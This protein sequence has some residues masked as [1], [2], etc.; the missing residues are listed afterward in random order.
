MVGIV[1]NKLVGIDEVDHRLHARF[2]RRLG[3]QVNIAAGIVADAAVIP[4]VRIVAVGI[5]AVAAAAGVVAP[6]LA[7]HAPAAR[8][9]LLIVQIAVGIDH[10]DEVG[11]PVVDQ[12]GDL[13]IASVVLAE[14]ADRL[15]Q[16]VDGDGLARVVEC[17]EKHLGF[18]GLVD[19]DVVRQL[20]G[21]D[22]ITLVRGPQRELLAQNL[23]IERAE[24][25]E[26]ADH[27]TV[28]VEV[29][30]IPLR[31]AL[32][33]VMLFHVRD[34]DLDDEAELLQPADLILV[35]HQD[36]LLPWHELHD[37]EIGNLA[38]QILQI[39]CIDPLQPYLHFGVRTGVGIRNAAD[40]DADAEAQ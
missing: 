39:H 25:I 36:Q 5:H 34:L 3:S 19:L 7:P 13:R 11:L 33:G 8:V 29:A 6:V 14:I 15:D 31:S 20:D 9:G 35:A 38:R 4:H 1:R 12:I 2:R 23:R 16:H 40:A 17:V 21:P 24:L 30:E 10:R 28:G 22:V 32:R 27:L 37:V 18:V 26:I